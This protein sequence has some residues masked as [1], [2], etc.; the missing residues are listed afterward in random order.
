MISFIHR[1]EK[2]IQ[3]NLIYKTQTHRHK[4]KQKTYGYQRGKVG[5]ARLEARDKHIHTTIHKTDK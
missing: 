4:T 3:M 1:I 5:M 2:M